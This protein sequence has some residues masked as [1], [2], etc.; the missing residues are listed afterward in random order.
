MERG[1]EDPEAE[2]GFSKDRTLRRVRDAA[3]R[4]EALT[5]RQR[6]VLHL[7]AAGESNAQIARGLEIA[8]ATVENH[9]K[10]VKARL[11]EGSRP[12]LAVIGYLDLTEAVPGPDD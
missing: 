10:E 5:A 7:I 9:I 4:I 6:E 12:M 11:R 3:L 8:Q 2:T 1:G